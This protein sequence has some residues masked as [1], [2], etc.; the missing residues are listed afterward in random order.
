MLCIIVVFSKKIVK[1]PLRAVK[2][3]FL[4]HPAIIFTNFKLSISFDLNRSKIVLFQPVKEQTMQRYSCPACDYIY[5]PEL[6]DPESGVPPGTAFED[7][8]D[9]WECPECGL[10][11]D[12]FEPL[13]E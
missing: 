3:G 11:K 13:E 10:S 4:T 8:P 12:D 5:D 1:S 6:G 7:L 9:E 2:F